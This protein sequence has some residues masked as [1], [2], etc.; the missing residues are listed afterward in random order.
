MRTV[1]LF[2]LLF[3]AAPATAQQ[4]INVAPGIDRMSRTDPGPNEIRALR[5]DLCQPGVRLGATA[6]EDRGQVTS[7]WASS[8]GAVAA[9]NGGYFGP[10]FTSD[11]GAAAG[12]GEVWPISTDTNYRGFIAIGAHQLTHSQAP[13]VEDLPPW[14][15]EA[16][17]GDA[18]LVLNGQAVDC[19]GCGFNAKHPRTAIGYSADRR[20]WYSVVVDGRS[21]ES[22]GMTI[23]E[24]AVL[25]A[26]FGV[27]RAMNVDGGGS[28]AMWIQ[29]L[30]VVNVPSDGTERVVGNHL[31]V[32]Y[33]AAD[34]TAHNCPDIT[35]RGYLDSATCTL[36]GWAQDQDQPD[37]PVDVHV[38]ID[39]PAGSGAPGFA[40]TADT[41]RADLCTAIGSC[42]H[43][44]VYPVPDEF[45][46]GQPHTAHAYAINLGGYAQNPE[47]TG[48]P[49]TFTCDPPP[50]PPPDAGVD[51]GIDAG[52]DAPDAGI[53][54]PD[55]GIDAPDAGVDGPD[56]GVD[57]PDAGVDAP[58]AGAPEEDAGMPDIGTPPGGD[59]GQVSMPGPDGGAVDEPDAGEPD[60]V[61]PDYP[62]SV[63][64]GCSA[65]G[66]STSLGGVALL[67]ALALRRRRRG[68]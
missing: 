10:G 41:Y 16:I 57:A 22:V 48:S 3:A 46:D 12:A 38:Y 40:L 59:G 62:P 14:T 1:I 35:P 67:C 7:A 50:P 61:E 42:N 27:D 17:N 9:T 31:G 4:W 45:R 13:V 60:P 58:D 19:G 68:R 33:D 24:L 20:Y 53:D 25:M 34:T 26:G 52:I 36:A 44:F 65:L 37:T 6:Y 55:A 64:D 30:G 47:L 21:D 66:G 54:A 39:G 32:F 49:K 5:I 15:E 56:A 51:A 8:A 28:S 29:G 43:G 18:T 63:T 2:A 23:D 11:G